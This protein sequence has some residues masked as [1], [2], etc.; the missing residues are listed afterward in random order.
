MALS[1]CVTVVVYFRLLMLVNGCWLLPCSLHTGDKLNTL[2]GVWHREREWKKLA[3][4]AEKWLDAGIMTE[5][6]W[7]MMHKNIMFFIL[8]QKYNPTTASIIIAIKKLRQVSF[9]RTAITRSLCANMES[10]TKITEQCPG[11]STAMKELKEKANPFLMFAKLSSC[12]FFFLAG[13]ANNFHIF[14]SLEITF[15]KQTKVMLFIL[16]Y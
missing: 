16:I 4:T 9:Q 6:R 3:P 10:R 15:G 8:C 5:I 12:W 2:P 11:W 13:F 14:S 7:K 1:L